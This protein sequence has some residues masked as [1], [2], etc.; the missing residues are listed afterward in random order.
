MLF[1]YEN[2]KSSKKEIQEL[3]IYADEDHVHMQKS[4][5]EKGKKSRIVPILTPGDAVTATRTNTNYVVTEYGMVNL[6]GATTWQRAERLISIADPDC[7]EESIAQA[8]KLKI[9]RK[10]NKKWLPITKL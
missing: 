3:H 6:K 7:R 1:K 5:K 9:W 2:E 4:D 10:S 8:E